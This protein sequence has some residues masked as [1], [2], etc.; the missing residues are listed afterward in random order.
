MVLD[1][2][3]GYVLMPRALCLTDATPF[4]RLSTAFSSTA[5]DAQCKIFKSTEYGNVMIWVALRGEKS[6]TLCVLDTSNSLESVH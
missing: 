2:S 5:L 6:S 1:I 4:A 3:S